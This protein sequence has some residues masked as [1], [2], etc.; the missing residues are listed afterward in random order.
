MWSN[1]WSADVTIRRGERT[2]WHQRSANQ[3]LILCDR[4]WVMHGH[5]TPELGRHEARWQLFDVSTLL[6]TE[7]FAITTAGDRSLCEGALQP[8]ELY[9]FLSKSNSFL[10]SLQWKSRQFLC[11]WLRRP[12]RR[13]HF[14]RLPIGA[15]TRRHNCFMTF[16]EILP[17][18][19]Y[20]MY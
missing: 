12:R 20:G 18:T 2:F 4:G 3:N 8:I 17:V 9:S 7:F 10:L 6:R 15:D 19:M 1:S 13:S 5:R 11:Y 16:S 14:F